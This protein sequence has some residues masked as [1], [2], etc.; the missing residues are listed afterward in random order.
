MDK[1]QSRKVTHHRL[2]GAKL[3]YKSGLWCTRQAQTEPDN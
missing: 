1:I 2:Y 3:A